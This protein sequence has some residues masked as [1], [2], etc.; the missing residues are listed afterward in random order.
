MA[1]ITA[2]SYTVRQAEL[3]NKGWNLISTIAAAI[4]PE[5]ETTYF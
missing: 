3:C 4:A 2:S 5:E 1:R